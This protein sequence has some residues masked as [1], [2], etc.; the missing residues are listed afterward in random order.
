MSSTSGSFGFA[1]GGTAAFSQMWTSIADK[2]ALATA[3][4]GQITVNTAANVTLSTA[5]TTT[6]GFAIIRGI[7][8]VTVAGTIIPQISL[9]VAATPQIQANSYFKVSPIGGTSVATVGNWS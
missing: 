2:A 3:T 4:T 9:G 1:L 8:R 6:T 7:I 5:N